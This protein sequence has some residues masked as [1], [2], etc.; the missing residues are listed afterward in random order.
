M[1]VFFHSISC[2]IA[3]AKEKERTKRKREEEE[4]RR[5]YENAM[6]ALLVFIMGALEIVYGQKKENRKCLTEQ[7]SLAIVF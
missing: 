3:A 4:R 2:I 6:V 5:I 1:A 7:V